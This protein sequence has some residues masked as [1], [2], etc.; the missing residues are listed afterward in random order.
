MTALME[1][2][3]RLAGLLGWSELT[4]AGGALLGRP[5]GGAENSRGQAAVPDWCGDWSAAG[6]ISAE[7]EIDIFHSH[8]SVRGQWDV[9]QHA[10]ANIVDDDR[11]AATREAIVR[12]VIGKL[13]AVK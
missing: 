8:S 4:D 13:E 3:R 12:A 1:L 9:A 6:P 5:P 7:H 11:D 10:R 2:T